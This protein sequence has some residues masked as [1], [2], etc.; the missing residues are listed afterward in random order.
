MADETF[1]LLPLQMDPQ[2]KAITAS[3]SS[4]Q[5]E[6]EL[7]E[8]NEAHRSILTLETPGQT[9]PP[10]VPIN[11][12]RSA[13]I[14]KLRESG[15]AAYKKG[16]HLEAHRF[17]TQAIDT[18]LAR[19]GWEPS[20]LVREELAMLYS[21]RAQAA[22]AMQSWGE[23]AVDAQTSVDMK[24]VQNAKAWWRRGRCLVE[25]GRIKEAREWVRQGLEFDS[26]E[27]DLRAL[28]DE[29][30]GLVARGKSD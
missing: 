16:Q 4:A 14:N 28:I 30:E 20:Q 26:S 29:I 12:K 2:T 5:L 25:M 27:A 24:R 11:P 23:A 10:P 15:N 1:T 8:L 19:P 3:P 22:M 13:A 6:K 7:M 17:Y 21:N 9:P 18:A